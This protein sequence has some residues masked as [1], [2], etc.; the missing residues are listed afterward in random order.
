MTE[1]LIPL[2]SNASRPSF[3]AMLTTAISQSKDNIISDTQEKEDSDGWLNVD[4]Q[5][6]DDMLEKTMG[7]SRSKRLGLPEN[8]DIDNP[9]GRTEEDRAANEQAS[10]L[11]DLAQKVESF[12]E[13]EGSVGGAKFDE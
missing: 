9:E 3:S 2:L 4:A 13:G 5:N 1:S 11:Q 6:F 10:R 8:M 7:A 12:V